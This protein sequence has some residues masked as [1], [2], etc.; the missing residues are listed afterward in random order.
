MTGPGSETHPP[1]LRGNMLLA[2]FDSFDGVTYFFLSSATFVLLT[3][4]IF[5]TLGLWIGGLTW[6]RFKRRFLAAR[7]SIEELKSE[8]ALLKRRVAEQATRPRPPAQPGATAPP[9]PESPPARAF[10]VWTE[11]G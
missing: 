7:D 2:F 8:L 4:A 10:T 5:F 3:A 9:P 6:G 1:P 11:P